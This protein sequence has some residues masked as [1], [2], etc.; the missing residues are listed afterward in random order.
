MRGALDLV[1]LL[2]WAQGLMCLLGIPAL[3]HL[4]YQ[5]GDAPWFDGHLAYAIGVA[6]LAPFVAWGIHRK[7]RWAW[8]LG[9]LH[10]LLQLPVLPFL[11]PFGIIQLVT[12]AF[13]AARAH[14]TEMAPA[15]PGLR[16]RRALVYGTGL[17]WVGLWAWAGVRFLDA[18]ALPVWRP[19]ALALILPLL[20]FVDVAV[21]ECGHL[22][23]GWTVDF[24]FERLCVGPVLIRRF[25]DGWGVTLHPA[26]TWDGGFAAALPSDPRQIRANLLVFLAGGPAASLLLCCVCI[27]CFANSPGTRLAPW[28][29]PI[30]L[31][32]AWSAF[33]FVAN[34]IPMRAGVA[35][36][37]G[38]W[39][40]ELVH[41]TPHGRRYCAL[42][43]MA[44]SE[45]NEM[46]PADWHHRWIAHALAVPDPSPERLSA[47]LLAYTHHLDR[48]EVERAGACLDEAITLQHRLPSNHITRHLWLERA[49][50]L[51]HYRRDALNARQA[52]QRGQS[53]LP[54]ERSLLLR[55][56]CALLTAEGDTRTA[57]DLLAL[58][59][60]VLG[61]S[62]RSGIA[63]FEADQL[64][65]LANRPGASH[66]V[67]PEPAAVSR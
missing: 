19:E 3:L 33:T 32:G 1:Q 31:L 37:D 36:T 34:S 23:A 24:R 11:T 64:D 44:S 62:R 61:H 15:G 10:G 52:W 41:G 38:A 7:R 13:P 30:G 57:S 9:L 14:F 28:A 66:P 55:A 59:E 67:A 39:I 58:A 5:Q 20:V 48:G 29:E 43:A 40:A 17:L 16:W 45:Y 8:P 51:A 26:L 2:L 21:H 65:A 63:S 60:N 53:G 49:Y 12:F 25:Q 54:V 47:L 42:Y 4:A 22:I 27:I 50:F 56:E 46:R 35:L 6:A 18:Q